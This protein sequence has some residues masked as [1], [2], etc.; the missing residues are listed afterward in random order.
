[1]PRDATHRHEMAFGQCDIE[2]GRGSFCI[3]EEHLVEITEPVEQY[4][5][6][7]QTAPYGLVLD[8]HRG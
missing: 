7:G 1:M 2:Y 8:H 3:L 6:C 5:I 4:D